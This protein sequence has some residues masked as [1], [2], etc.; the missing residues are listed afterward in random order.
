M[1]HSR[2][3]FVDCLFAG[4]LFLVAKPCFGQEKKESSYSPLNEEPIEMVVVHEK[5]KT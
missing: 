1:N 5:S 4:A 3:H 2:T